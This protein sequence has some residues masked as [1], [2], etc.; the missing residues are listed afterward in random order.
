MG[1]IEGI[2]RFKYTELIDGNYERESELLIDTKDIVRSIG[3][4]GETRNLVD[5]VVTKINNK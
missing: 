1:K 4:F 3:K 5:L 2:F